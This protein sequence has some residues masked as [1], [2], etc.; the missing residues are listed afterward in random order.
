MVVSIQ[1]LLDREKVVLPAIWLQG[2]GNFFFAFVTITVSECRQFLGIGFAF[3]IF[4]KFPIAK[5]DVESFGDQNGIE[6]LPVGSGTLLI[7]FLYYFIYIREFRF[8][9]FP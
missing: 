7:I 5:N 9:P 1:F 6:V 2:F 4:C 8:T 3:G